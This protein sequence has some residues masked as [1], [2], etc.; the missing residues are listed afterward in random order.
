MR[1]A[2]VALLLLVVLLVAVDFGARLWAER[3]LSDEIANSLDLSQRP[4]V[5][6]G[7]FPFLP[8]ALGG[9]LPSVSIRASEFQGADVSVHA[10]TLLFRDVSFSL[11]EVLSERQQEIH[12]RTGNGTAS[13]TEADATKALRR[14][15]FPLRVRFEAGSA[16]VSSEDLPL[17]EIQTGV[18]LRGMSVLL[19]PVGQAGQPSFRFRLPQVVRGLRYTKLRLMTGRAVLSFRLSDARLRLRRR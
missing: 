11:G 5:S 13:L 15:G 19:T 3:R 9:R 17:G 10:L 6:L 1:R 8:D 7:G 16:F 18:A 2:L 14:T 12:V 4:D